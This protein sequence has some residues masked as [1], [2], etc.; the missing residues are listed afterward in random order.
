MEIILIIRIIN[1]NYSKEICY[2]F[3][4]ATRLQLGFNVVIF[5]KQHCRHVY[6]ECFVSF[7]AR[8]VRPDAVT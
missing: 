3:T 5:F 7:L 8:L 6:I 1:G 2:I 4:L